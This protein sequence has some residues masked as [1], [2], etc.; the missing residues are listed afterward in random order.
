M[1]PKS[2]VEQYVNID[3]VIEKAR[4][5][6]TESGLAVPDPLTLKAVGSCMTRG[7]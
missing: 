2:C 6:M 3:A 7:I 1:R 5:I 4:R